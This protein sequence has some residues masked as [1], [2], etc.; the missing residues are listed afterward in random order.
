MLEPS[1]GR[2]G[3]Q[4]TD[5]TPSE[6]LDW[7]EL[8]KGQHDIRGYGVEQVNA[9]PG[10]AAGASFTF[11]RNYERMLFLAQL[12]GAPVFHVRPKTWQKFL[13]L[14]IK[15]SIKGARRKTAIKKGVAELI[16]MVHP[17]VKE[18]CYGPRG[19]LIDG[20]TD[21]LSIAHYIWN[22]YNL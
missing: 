11:G 15:P 19:G 16:T 18:Q 12:S 3:F 4:E 14:S 1:S 20:R 9:V 5:L 17:K 6:L 2:V 8:V 22:F 7:L 13:G 21:S 10:S